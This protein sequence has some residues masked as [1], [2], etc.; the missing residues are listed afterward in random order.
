MRPEPGEP[1]SRP[2]QP[3]ADSPHPV[4]HDIID[5]RERELADSIKPLLSESERA[6]FAVGYFFI[7]GFKLVAPELER[8]AELRL[9]VGNVSDQRTV[10]QLAESHTA[11]Q[12]IAPGGQLAFILPHKFFNAQYGQPLRDLLAAGRHVRHVVHFGDQQIFPGATNYVCLLFLARDGAESCRWVRA[13]DLH[14][15]LT[16]FSAPET[17][18][19][20]DRIT[21]AE[22]NFAVG[23]GA[24]LFEKLQRMPVKLGEVADIFVG[25]QT[26]ADD[27]FIMN[28]VSETARTITLASNSLEC[29]WTFEKE[30]VH[31]VV[32]G[33]DVSAYGVLRNRQFILFPYELTGERADLIALAKLSDAWPRAAEYLKRNRRRLEEREHNRLKGTGSWHGYIYLKNMARQGQPKVCVPRL[34]EELHAAPDF[35]G[36][37]FLDNVDVGGLTMRSSGSSTGLGY[38]L[39]L[40][41]SRLVR[42]YF[43]HVSAPF[44]GG[45][46][47][48]NKQFLSLI[49]FPPLDFAVAS[50]QAEHDALV[51]LVARILA[52]KRAS[53]A[54]D[55]SALEH[56]IDERVYRLYGLTRDEVKLVEEPRP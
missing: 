38:L 7:S 44:R 43:P 11:A 20:A 41:N 9:L 48:A 8:L 42:W 45:W 23:A 28:F 10:E 4:Q 33:T 1:A 56:E 6:K 3:V 51:G 46:R 24:G 50:E 34:V 40:L 15:W 35:G 52:V 18:L 22:W 53:P 12:L 26:S 19:I 2:G 32:S 55:T 37:H 27:V 47:S 5:N 49:P 36:T 31:P 30:L 16:S 14:V 21:A 17:P 13:D 39:A 25:L 29:D 54:A